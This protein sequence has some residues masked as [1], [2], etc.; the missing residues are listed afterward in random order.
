[1][2]VSFA[3][4]LSGER[5]HVAEVEATKNR[6]IVLQRLGTAVDWPSMYTASVLASP[7]GSRVTIRFFFFFFFCSNIFIVYSG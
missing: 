5:E 1:M 6:L 2:H 4:S 7:R 3:M